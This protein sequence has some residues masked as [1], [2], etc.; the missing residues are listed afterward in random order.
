MKNLVH[1]LT[2]I[3]VCASVKMLRLITNF[4]YKDK[5]DNWRLFIDLHKASLKR[6]LLLNGNS[7]LSI[8][9]AH[10]VQLG[11]TYKNNEAVILHSSVPK[12]FF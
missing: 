4:E 11:K 5:C 3:M 6:V 12:T 7:N 8:P 2:P 1:S 10:S 9:V